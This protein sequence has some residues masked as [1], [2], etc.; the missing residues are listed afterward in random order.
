MLRNLNSEVKIRFLVKSLLVR[1]PP[2][3]TP[4]TPLLQCV[5]SECAP[6]PSAMLVVGTLRYLLQCALSDM[7]GK[8]DHQLHCSTDRTIEAA[9][10][11][12]LAVG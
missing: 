4:P 1:T 8:S 2:T 9:A 12:T 3:L 10:E 11:K 5:L 6:L 7:A